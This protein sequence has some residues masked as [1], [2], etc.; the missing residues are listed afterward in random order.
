LINFKD[1]GEAMTL[2][3]KKFMDI[4]FAEAKKGY[5]EGGIPVSFSSFFDL[6]VSIQSFIRFH[7]Y[8]T[9]KYIN[10]TLC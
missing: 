5:D 6:A 7:K 3:D 8:F 2:D 9:Q 1:W 10:S 4:A